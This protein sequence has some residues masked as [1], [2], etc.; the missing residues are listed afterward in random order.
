MQSGR[1]AE[2]ERLFEQVSQLCRG[3]GLILPDI[4]LERLAALS[5]S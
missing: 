2:A 4:R 1:E 3:M 5:S